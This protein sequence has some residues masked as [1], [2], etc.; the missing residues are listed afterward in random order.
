M[1][2]IFIIQMSI[3]DTLS[4]TYHM[5]PAEMGAYMR[6]YLAHC[7]AGAEGLPADDARLARLAGITNNATWAKVK[8]VVLEKFDLSTDRSRYTQKRVVENLEKIAALSASAKAKALKRWG[9]GDAGASSQQCSGNAT[10]TQNPKPSTQG[11]QTPNTCTD[12]PRK[13]EA[14]PAGG[15]SSDKSESGGGAVSFTVMHYLTDEALQAARAAAE[16]WDVYRLAGT[17]D[18]GI[19]NGMRTAPRNPCQAFPAWCAK[20]TKGKRP[21]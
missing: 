6:L 14:A 21:S 5:T 11:V 2:D 10:P 19:R 9:T 1:S 17:Y 15:G 16:G 18:E 13:G 8:R 7:K 20:Y 3:G 4:D 12:Q